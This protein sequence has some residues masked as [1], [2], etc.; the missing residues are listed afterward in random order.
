MK[1][2]NMLSKKIPTQKSAYCVTAFIGRSGIGGT[3][4]W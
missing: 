4:L 1:F 2:K 3:N